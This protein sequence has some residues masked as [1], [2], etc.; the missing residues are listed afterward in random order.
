MYLRT[1]YTTCMPSSSSLSSCCPLPH[2][3][4]STAELGPVVHASHHPILLYTN[5]V[6]KTR[7]R[8]AL[9]CSR[10]QQMAAA[11]HPASVLDRLL[12]QVA[13]KQD[14]SSSPLVVPVPGQPRGGVRLLYTCSRVGVL[15]IHIGQR[16]Q[17]QTAHGHGQPIG[18]A[19]F[20]C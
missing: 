20:C 13:C 8:L 10:L 2:R 4:Q 17:L 5:L 7:S 9:G 18:L 16:P 1:C 3:H 15:S 19:T 11:S 6:N 12:L 14:I